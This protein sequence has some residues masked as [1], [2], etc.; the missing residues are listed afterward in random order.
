MGSVEDKVEGTVIFLKRY[1]RKDEEQV[2]ETACGESWELYFRGFGYPT[3]RLGEYKRGGYDQEVVRL[4]DDC[5]NS[6]NN[7]LRI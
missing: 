4:D 6:S 3:W 5:D 2:D 7:I 1:A